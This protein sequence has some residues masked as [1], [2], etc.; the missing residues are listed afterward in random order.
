MFR[1]SPVSPDLTE[2]YLTWLVREDAEEGVD[3]DVDRLKWMW[4]VTV[5]QDAT[6]IE[7][8]GRGVASCRYQPGPYSALEG[9]TNDFTRWHLGQMA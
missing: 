3:Y 9:W 4:D 2:V 7:N 6:I 1:F 5:Q 8:N